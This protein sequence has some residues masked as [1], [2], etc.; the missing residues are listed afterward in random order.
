MAECRAANCAITAR[1]VYRR[2]CHLRLLATAL[3]A[4]V[5]SWLDLC[6]HVALCVCARF[7][8]DA[9]RLRASSCP[10]MT[11]TWGPEV[12]SGVAFRWSPQHVTLQNTGGPAFGAS[13]LGDSRQ[14]ARFVSRMAPPIES[15]AMYDMCWFASITHASITEYAVHGLVI[16]ACRS[17]RYLR[18]EDIDARESW[19]MVLTALERELLREWWRAIASC[20]QLEM[21]HYPALRLVAGTFGAKT[22][23]HPALRVVDIANIECEE[24]ECAFLTNVTELST[25][26]SY[27]PLS[28]CHS[29][30]A[31]R[32]L[33][34]GLRLTRLTISDTSWSYLNLPVSPTLRTLELLDI[35]GGGETMT[36]NA[37]VACIPMMAPN[38][39]TLRVKGSTLYTHPHDWSALSQLTQLETLDL[40][41]MSISDAAAFALPHLPSVTEYRAP[42]DAM[43]HN[44]YVLTNPIVSGSPESETAFEALAFASPDPELVNVPATLSIPSLAFS[45]TKGLHLS[46]SKDQVI[47]F[48]P[49]QSPRTSSPPEL[50]PELDPDEYRLAFP[51]LTTLYHR[52][53]Y[54]AR[55]LQRS[56]VKLAHI[57]GSS[58]RTAPT[59][60]DGV[61]DVQSDLGDNQ[62]FQ[63]FCI[64][65]IPPHPK[66]EVIHVGHNLLDRADLQQL[67]DVRISDYPQLREI[68]GA[69]TRL[70]VLTLGTLDLDINLGQHI[71]LGDS[72]RLA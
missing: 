47:L 27:S 52:Q 67:Y 51:N 30:S 35:I 41:E 5:F 55:T 40:E 45:S 43:C 18:V 36:L 29:Y 54:V 26:H 28:T 46:E 15:L 53:P 44:L 61:D 6:D 11:V 8:S 37:M 31:L 3:V 16:D 70:R 9:S 66:L 72:Q 71:C 42:A 7:L 34:V 24:P 39:K 50:D 17:L 57:L 20:T 63:V 32:R 62:Q 48:T 58:Q 49:P 65:D 25:C 56:A 19:G 22:R 10:R 2:P 1:E 69:D 38:L 21:L 33:L 68:V 64:N 23:P 13:T 59:A 4:Q 12:S 60:V 14:V